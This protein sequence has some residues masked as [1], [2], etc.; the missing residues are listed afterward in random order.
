MRRK[1]SSWVT[2]TV[3][4]LVALL[5]VGGAAFALGG[6]PRSTEPPVAP[7][8]AELEGDA[9]EGFGPGDPPDDAHGACVSEVAQSDAVGGKNDNHGGAVSEAARF[10]CRGLEPG[11]WHRPG[12]GRRWSDQDKPGNG[13]RWSDEGKPGNGPPWADG[14]K[15]GNGPPP[16]A[17][18]GSGPPW[19]GGDN[20]DKPGNGPP[21]AGGDKPGKGPPPWAGTG[22]GPPWAGDDEDTA[23]E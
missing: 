8:N 20:A 16:W 2:A 11:Q 9:A 5:I 1:H 22:D 17:G 4:A 19:A 10:T 21:W 3:G 13:P 12:N 15:P 18:Q 7:A 14:D 6:E 23:E